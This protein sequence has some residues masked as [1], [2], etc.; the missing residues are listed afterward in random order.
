LDA[1]FEAMRPEYEAAIQTVGIQP[2]WHVLDAGCGSGSFLQL[3]AGLVGSSGHISGLDLDPE[4]IKVVETLVKS[5]QT[6]CSVE[7]RRGEVTSLPYRDNRFDAVWCANVTQYLTDGELQKMLAEFRRVVQ[8][9]GLV[10][11]KDFDL[12]LQQFLPGDPVALWK[13]FEK[14][15]PINSQ[16]R[17]TFRVLDLPI[18]LRRAGLTDIR[19]ETR[20]CERQ[21]PLRPV[22]QEFLGHAFRFLASIAENIGLPEPMLSTWRKLG[23]TDSPDHIMKH[24]DFHYREGFAVIGARVPD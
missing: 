7:A 15:R 20:V 10:V 8:P 18:W 21:A 6:G 19:Y 9:N 4:N 12:T 3:L 11:V 16:V 14:L 17:G 5:R 24:P 13:L 2:G 22:E 1:H 23:D